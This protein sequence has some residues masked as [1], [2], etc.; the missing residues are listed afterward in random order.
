MWLDWLVSCD[1]GFGLSAFWCLLSVPTVGFLLPWTWGIS[2]WLLQQSTAAAPYLER[3]LSPHCC[4]SW[5]WMWSILICGL[6]SGFFHLPCFP[7]SSDFDSTKEPSWI[8]PH[9]WGTGYQ[10]CSYLLPLKQQLLICSLTWWYISQFTYFGHFDK[11][12]W[13]LEFIHWNIQTIY[14]DRTN[15]AFLKATSIAGF[16]AEEWELPFSWRHI[17]DAREMWRPMCRQAE[18]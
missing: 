14:W 2:S 9:T 7:D 10:A 8:K 13:N 17:R 5:P 18:T 15:L 4:H 11:K 12:F 6:S 16:Y 1:C 3:G